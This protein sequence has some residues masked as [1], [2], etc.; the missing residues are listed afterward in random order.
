MMAPRASAALLALGLAACGEAVP[1]AAPPP[2]PSAAPAVA[3]TGKAPL[4]PPPAAAPTPRP[5]PRPDE[6]LPGL[7]RPFVTVALQGARAPIIAVHGRGPRDLWFLADDPAATT[8][9][10]PLGAVLHSDGEKLLE[11]IVPVCYGGIAGIVTS[12]NEVVML[13]TNLWFRGVPSTFRGFID[14]HPSRGGK[15]RPNCNTD[16]YSAGTTVGGDEHLWTLNCGPKGEDCQIASTGGRSASFPAFDPSSVNPGEPVSL[17]VRGLWMKAPADGWM[18]AND[19]D[20]HGFLWRYNGVVW[21][22]TA[23]VDEGLDVVALWVDE[24][25]HPW[26]LARRGK[27]SPET[28]ILRYDGQALRAIGVPATFA[29]TLVVGTSARDVWFLGAGAAVHQWDGQRLRAGVAPFPVADA[30]AA[31]GG[32]VWITGPVPDSGGPPAGVVAHTRAL[33]E[34][35]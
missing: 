29:A 34:V 10:G 30:W 12:R 15:R 1:P 13:G 4:P 28:G 6:P 11:R 26:L 14:L 25:T 7:T 5:A 8:G 9:P 17:A 32:E 27:D 19:E 20:G 24:E 2:A 35:R 18:V 31:P 22:R 23:T 21:V 33:P 16:W 3:T